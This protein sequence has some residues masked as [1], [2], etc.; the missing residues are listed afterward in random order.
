VAIDD[1]GQDEPG[2]RVDERQKERLA[3][4]SRN[5]HM[6]RSVF[7]SPDGESVLR[8]MMEKFYK[9]SSHVPGDSHETAFNE[10]RRQVVIYILD[11][12]ERAENNDEN[13]AE[14]K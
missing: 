6:F 9:Y 14:G 10:G 5:N 3:E 7:T 12:L 1:F 4:I 11:R 13:M 2:H 8:D